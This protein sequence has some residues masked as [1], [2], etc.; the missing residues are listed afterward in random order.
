MSID[1]AMRRP[2]RQRVSRTLQD[3]A[4][5]RSA[6]EEGSYPWYDAKADA[7]KPVWDKHAAQHAALIKRIQDVK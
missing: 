4:S 1:L 5:L 2:S 7:V 3:I 6:L